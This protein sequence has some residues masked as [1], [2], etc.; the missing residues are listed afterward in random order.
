MPAD[1]P[2]P[3]PMH[4]RNVDAA[5][6][7]LLRPGVLLA[8][9]D[10]E[11]ASLAAKFDEIERAATPYNARKALAAALDRAEQERIRADVAD[12]CCRVL[13]ERFAPEANYVDLPER[14]SNALSV[15][16][17]RAER[18]ERENREHDQAMSDMNE[19]RDA[20][21]AMAARLRIIVERSCPT[22]SPDAVWTPPDVIEVRAALSASSDADGWLQR[23]RDS[24]VVEALKEVNADAERDILA[25]NPITGAHHRAIERALARP[26]AGTEGGRG[27]N[28]REGQC[29][30]SASTPAN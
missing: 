15:V 9:L 17:D 28:A 11:I 23:E 10:D 3:S 18:A 25:G 6:R 21:L 26:A 13:A 14:I 30:P 1:A 16:T 27:S 12:A 8:T 29:P 2:S 4:S 19:L 5:K 24:A 22:L 20:A 7:W